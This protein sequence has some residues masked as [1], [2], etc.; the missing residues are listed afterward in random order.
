MPEEPWWKLAPP[1]VVNGQVMPSSWWEAAK[2][3]SLQT[4]SNPFNVAAV[5]WIEAGGWRAGRIGRSPYQGPCGFNRACNIPW[6]EMYIPERQIERACR[7][8]RGDLERRL[9]R[10]NAK[11][12]ENNYVPDV[13]HLRNKLEREARIKVSSLGPNPPSG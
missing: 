3:G 13:L 6:E 5:M 4:G 8:L 10:Y 1:P 2:R 9:R 11:S 7:L 12:D